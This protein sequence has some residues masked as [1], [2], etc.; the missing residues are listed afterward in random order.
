M[1]TFTNPSIFED[2]ENRVPAFQKSGLLA[3]VIGKSESLSVLS[4]QN[5]NLRIQPTRAAK[6]QKQGLHDPSFFTNQTNISK[7]ITSFNGNTFS[8]TGLEFSIYSD[9][10]E[11]VSKQSNENKSM[12]EKKALLDCANSKL[13]E[14]KPQRGLREI[15]I[16]KA[17]MN[18]P[19]KHS[20][21]TSNSQNCEMTDISMGTPMSVCSSPDKSQEA[22][23]KIREEELYD[24]LEYREDIYKYLRE[25][26]KL[27]RPRL[28]YMAKQPDI[29]A[30]MRFILV[31]W[32]VEVAEE[33]SLTS[34]TL[35]LAVSY[36]DRFLSHMSVK[37]DKLQLVG[38][39]AMFIASKYEEI[40]P[41]EV[42]QFAYI[43]D[44]TY[45]VAH[46][47]R[48]EHLILK[49]L[50]FDMAVPTPWLFM[51][52]MARHLRCDEK[53]HSLALFISELTV[54][55][56]EGFLKFLPSLIAASAL[57]LARYTLGYDDAWPQCMTDAFDYVLGDLRE[58]YELLETK[59][60]EVP[61]AEKHA[62]REKYDSKKFQSVSRIS[63]RHKSLFGSL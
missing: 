8:S 12:D 36:I 25:S 31:E 61:H 55:D 19:S 9:N 30:S 32:M 60:S 7:P 24:M 35:F 56:P 53:E 42:N 2:Q 33:Y 57:T 15:T 44:N 4:T 14:Q 51:N 48:M 6:L 23:L 49:V 46:I 11:N 16:P 47:L 10:S 59:F 26:E 29:T 52:F 34:E 3:K 58:C 21:S 63:S 28:N 43:T 20:V 45:K 62:L 38:T 27:H 40:Y 37:R 54:L 22:L 50:S 39:T 5:A 1:A 41:P 17:F 18:L 13:V